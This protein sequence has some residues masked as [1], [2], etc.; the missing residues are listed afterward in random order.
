LIEFHSD[1]VAQIR[2]A[3]GREHNFRVG[4]H[5]LIITGVCAECRAPKRPTRKLDLV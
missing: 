4:G 5:R 1:E 2:D 3:V